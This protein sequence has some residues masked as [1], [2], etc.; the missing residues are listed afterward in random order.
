[1]VLVSAV[2]KAEG[3]KSFNADL[4]CVANEQWLTH[5]RLIK[6]EF[7]LNALVMRDTDKLVCAD[8]ARKYPKARGYNVILEAAKHDAYDKCVLTEMDTFFAQYPTGKELVKARY[9]PIKILN[10]HSMYMWVKRESVRGSESTAQY[11][12]KNYTNDLKYWS[13]L[14]PSLDDL[15]YTDLDY[16]VPCKRQ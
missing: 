11:I 3:Y 14:S 4:T 8:E 7:D 16:E 13:W 6:V 9:A 1:M 2:A 5:N 15:Y 12:S 10:D